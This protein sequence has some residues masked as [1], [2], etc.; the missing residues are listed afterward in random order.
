MA[1]LGSLWIARNVP[2]QD[3]RAGATQ[4]PPVSNGLL[5]NGGASYFFVALELFYSSTD[6]HEKMWLSLVIT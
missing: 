3:F 2:R 1:F 5:W 4:H 6:T